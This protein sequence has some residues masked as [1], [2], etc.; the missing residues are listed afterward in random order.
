MPGRA[1]VLRVGCLN[2]R[3]FWT[4]LCENIFV[5]ERQDQGPSSNGVRFTCA[6]M[7]AKGFFREDNRENAG[8]ERNIRDPPSFKDFS[9]R[10]L[11]VTEGI[12]QRVMI[13]ESHVCS[14]EISPG[15][16]ITKLTFNFN[17]PRPL[18]SGSK[19][20]SA[21]VYFTYLFKFFKSLTT[22]KIQRVHKCKLS[23]S[24]TAVVRRKEIR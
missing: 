19:H 7:M 9:K 6:C 18:L 16:D 2:N 24:H 14:Q 22:S 5:S 21:S 20:F 15:Q 11:R 12:A 3:P 4:E 17:T 10:D 23:Q 1:F 8:G 13:L